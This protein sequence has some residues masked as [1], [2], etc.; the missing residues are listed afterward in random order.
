[1]LSY[2]TATSDTIF[3]GCTGNIDNCYGVITVSNSIIVML[4]SYDT[5]YESNTDTMTNILRSQRLKLI[6]YSI[7]ASVSTVQAFIATITLIISLIFTPFHIIDHRSVVYLILL[8]IHFYDQQDS[9]SLLENNNGECDMNNT[10]EMTR[11]VMEIA[12]SYNSSTEAISAT[13]MTTSMQAYPSLLHYDDNI[14]DISC[15]SLYNNNDCGN[16]KYIAITSRSSMIAL[17]HSDDEDFSAGNN[18]PVAVT[19]KTYNMPSAICD[20]IISAVN[21]VDSSAITIVTT[22]I[23]MMMT[24]FHESPSAIHIEMPCAVNNGI[25]SA[26]IAD[27]AQY[28]YYDSETAV[29]RASPNLYFDTTFN[30]ALDIAFNTDD[31]ALYDMTNDTIISVSVPNEAA[32]VSA[33]YDEV[34][35]AV[36]V[37]NEATFTPVT[38]MT[39]VFDGR[40]V[41]NDFDLYFDTLFDT[42]PLVY[43]TLDCSNPYFN[44]IIWLMYIHVIDEYL[45]ITGVCCCTKMGS[46]P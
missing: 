33:I 2:G 15:Q 40:T 36:S 24:A 14:L 42:L 21:N 28:D 22:A 23:I 13:M 46:I 38:N 31:E 1:M 8:Q 16:D 32:L 10:D 18:S 20:G 3:D 30:T 34:L 11:C 7:T 4:T 26:A 9:L 44:T 41:D 5:V 35:S 25:S 27:K 19:M 12:T 45:Y 39:T 37:A 29:S 6:S 17:F 43:N